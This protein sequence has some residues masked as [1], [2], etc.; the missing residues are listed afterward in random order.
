MEQDEIMSLL[1]RA[2]ACME[3]GELDEAFELF[4]K[5]T[6][7]GSAEAEYCLGKL[8]EEQECDFMEDLEDYDTYPKAEEHY[9]NSAEKG[10]SKSALALAKLYFSSYF[11]PSCFD[12]GHYW[13]ERAA[14]LGEREA[15]EYIQA[16]NEALRTKE[17]AEK[18][19]PEAMLKASTLLYQGKYLQKKDGEANAYLRMSANMDYLPAVEK[20]G[21]RMYHSRHFKEAAEYFER[22]L[23]LGSD[24]WIL[25]LAGLYADDYG[26]G[27][28]AKRAEELY[29]RALENGN[30]EALLRLGYLYAR[31]PDL[32]DAKKAI[33][34]FDEYE[35]RTGTHV[36]M[37]NKIKNIETLVKLAE[38]G[39]KESAF[40]LGEAYE[41]EGTGVP[42][43]YFSKRKWY[44]LAAE[45]G[46]VE[47]M[48]KVAD[49]Y[50]FGKGGNGEDDEVNLQKASYWYE[51][52]ANAGR[53][54]SIHRI[55]FMYHDGRGVERNLEKAIFW[56]EK[57]CD[58]FYF[59]SD[60]KRF[61][62]KWKGE[63]NG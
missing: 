22:A 40:K 18:G 55:A 46:H 9:M 47:A 31:D 20:L 13:Y 63:L 58:D 38:E 17:E 39:D 41:F 61:V 48:E 12:S 5:A 42:R 44:E 11:S 60:V 45:L 62:E 54:F 2:N 26:A 49:A 4:S 52:S 6:E 8:W 3:K 29:F 59:R 33:S 15:I 43:N 23:E 7:L 10:H 19:D 24:T 25:Q 16:H 50:Y 28:N 32:Y 57:L 1:E 34:Y 53:K 56:M 37:V 30:E 36:T 21:E 35:K 14:E 27:R 51:K